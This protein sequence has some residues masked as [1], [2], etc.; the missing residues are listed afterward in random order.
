M[1][2][3]KADHAALLREELADLDAQVAAGD[4]DAATAAGLRTKYE[5][6]LAAIG[7]AAID[8]AEA[9]PTNDPAAEKAPGG[10]TGRVSGRTLAGFAIVGVLIVAIGIFA[11]QSLESGGTAGAEG[12][13][14]DVLGGGEVDLSAITNDQM[15][16]VVS[17]NPDVV[18]MRLA[19]ARRYFEE[20]T[21]DKALDHYFEVLDRELHPEALANIGWMTYL[22]DR[23]DVAVDYLE[24]ALIV[25]TDYLPAKW[26]LANV[27]TTLGR[28][29]EAAIQLIE[30]LS[31]D[32]IPDEVRS[33]AET[34]L[35]QIEQS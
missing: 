29:D 20:G 22:S 24:R 32:D 12:V 25:R 23:P 27:Y 9:P 5:A 4:I 6:E 11:V 21:F 31:S 35:Q 7:D 13:A 19:L 2:D 18:G 17:E 14:S 26:F 1:S 8:P 10:L 34:L 15:E 33:G 30:L 16:A 28:T 3:P